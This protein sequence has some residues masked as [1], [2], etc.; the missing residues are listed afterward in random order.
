MKSKKTL[1]TNMSISEFENSYWYAK[2]LKDFARSLGLTSVSKL[3]KDELEKIIRKYL[4]SGKLEINIKNSLQKRSRLKDYEVGNL[5]L[6]RE[7]KNYT[8]NKITKTFI[9]N[10]AKKIQPYLVKKSGVWYWLNRWREEQLKLR[11]ITYSDLVNHFLK[12]SNSKEKLPKIPS[13]KFNNFISDYLE[14]KEGSRKDAL[15]TWEELK[16]LDIPKNYLA[17]KE[18]TKA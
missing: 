17:W 16:N 18:Y 12:L 6:D 2:E 13:T 15:E 7:I 5:S 3:R 11:K 1:S 8:S 10:E 14:A 9:L 4:T